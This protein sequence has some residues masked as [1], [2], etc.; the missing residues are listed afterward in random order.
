MKDD[1]R[2]SVKK[3]LNVYPYNKGFNPCWNDHAYAYALN[4]LFGEDAVN[5]MIKKVK[6][7]NK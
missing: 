4:K 2:E 3:L 6:G 7:E 5:D 1:L